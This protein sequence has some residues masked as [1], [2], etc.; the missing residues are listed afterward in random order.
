M[1]DVQARGD[2]PEIRASDAE[3]DQ[4]LALLRRHFGDG[5]LTLTELEERVADASEARTRGQLR[6]LTADL[7]ADSRP[8]HRTL[9]GRTGASLPCCSVYARR[10]VWS[11]GCSRAEAHTTL[12][13]R[14]RTVPAVITVKP[15]ATV[16]VL[17]S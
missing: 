16:K 8:G 6:A 14:T 5:R 1:T 10:P 17:P 11:T 4:T 15:A 9:P 3:R 2:D 13:C 7:P 12:G